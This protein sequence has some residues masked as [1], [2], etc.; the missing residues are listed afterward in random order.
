MLLWTD[1]VAST[2]SQPA[3]WFRFLAGWI[4]LKSPMLSEHRIFYLHHEN[5][6]IVGALY[7]AR[8]GNRDHSPACRRSSLVGPARVN[9]RREW[10]VTDAIRSSQDSGL[11]RGLDS[12]R[13]LPRSA[14][15]TSASSVAW[16]S[17][18]TSMT[19]FFLRQVHVV[20]N[21]PGPQSREIASHV[22]G[23][24]TGYERAASRYTVVQTH[25]IILGEEPPSMSRSYDDHPVLYSPVSAW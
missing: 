13:W 22:L 1:G 17:V 4:Q 6:R 5:M 23:Q 7:S 21:P 25:E 10:K 24:R 15:R 16:N 19:E 18:L 8:T 2:R 12:A 3:P 20:V 14:T 9:S 11:Q